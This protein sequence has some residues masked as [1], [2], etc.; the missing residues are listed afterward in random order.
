MKGREV[1]YDRSAVEREN[2]PSQLMLASIVR[3]LSN[4]LQVSSR[5]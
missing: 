5:Q 1:I 2:V 4:F 3:V